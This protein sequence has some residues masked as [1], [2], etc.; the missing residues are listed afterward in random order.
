[1]DDAREVLFVFRSLTAPCRSETATHCQRSAVA[2]AGPA[3]VLA[4][5]PGLRPLSPLQPAAGLTEAAHPVVQL[6]LE[7][8]DLRLHLLSEL[9]DLLLNRRTTRRLPCCLGPVFLPVA[10]PLAAVVCACAVAMADTSTKVAIVF[11]WFFIQPLPEIV[12]NRFPEKRYLGQRD[13]G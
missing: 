7:L 12:T 1:M 2:A 8:V 13:T 5:E 3:A 9:L 6:L 4:A 11:K 10:L